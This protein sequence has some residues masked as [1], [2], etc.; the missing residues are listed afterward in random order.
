M[1]RLHENA[2][3]QEYGARVREVEMGTFTLLMMST[4][5]GLARE[6]TVFYKWLA[7]CLADKCGVSYPLVMTWLRCRIAFAL[8]R[9]A[10]RALR[11]S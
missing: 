5:G 8:L 9:S 2:I 6:S 10:I 7:A 3:K 11:G 4:S 1:Y